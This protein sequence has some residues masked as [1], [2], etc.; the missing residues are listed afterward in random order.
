[1]GT[2]PQRRGEGRHQRASDLWPDCCRILV[3]VAA[4]KVVLV[5]VE[6]E[7]E[8]I[9][10]TTFPSYCPLPRETLANLNAF[11]TDKI[12]R[13]LA[14]LSPITW[15]D[16]WKNLGGRGSLGRDWIDVASWGT[17]LTAVLGTSSDIDVEIESAL[18]YWWDIGL[19]LRSSLVGSRWRDSCWTLGLASRTP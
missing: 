8:A 6:I 14:G 19:R 4:A 5:E 15:E 3:W 17:S 9:S 1:M 2:G 16:P 13:K 10:I 12:R 18:G 11:S 7:V